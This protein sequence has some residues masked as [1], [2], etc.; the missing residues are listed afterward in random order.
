MTSFQKFII[1]PLG[2]A[3]ILAAALY[4]V[5]VSPYRAQPPA[6]LG[7]IQNFS[8]TDS[9]NTTFT[10]ANLQNKVWVADFI[11]TSCAGVCPIMT[12]K[13]QNLYRS[14]ERE[15]GVA[16]VSISVDPEVDTPEKLTEYAK[17]FSADV[18]KW[19]FLTGSYDAIHELAVKSFKVGKVDE[20]IFHS[21]KFILVDRNMKIRGY[22]DSEDQG[23]LKKLFH[24]IALVAN[25][26]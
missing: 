22:Y 9:N 7:E 3:V 2:I 14:Y 20:P 24:D 6:V 10:Q 21:E 19:H 15:D 26:K 13:M 1:I 18:N 25:E 23:E 12:G 16:F 4:F 17:R 11:F 5:F 8:L